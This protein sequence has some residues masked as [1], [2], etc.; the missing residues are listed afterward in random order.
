MKCPSCAAQLGQINAAGEPII[1]NRGM[2]LKAA[3]VSVVC[4]KCK[5]DVPVVGELAKAM[6]ARL[7]LVFAR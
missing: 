3:G 5:A 7:L 2:I 6:S 4:P 1:R